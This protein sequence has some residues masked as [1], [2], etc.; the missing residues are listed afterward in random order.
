MYGGGTF[1]GREAAYQKQQ[2][3]TFIS[4]GVVYIGDIANN[5]KH[6]VHR[7]RKQTLVLV[8][9][10]SLEPLQTLAHELHVSIAGGKC[11]CVYEGPPVVNL[12]LHQ[13]IGRNVV[14]E[15]L[16]PYIYI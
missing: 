11:L 12:F 4:A 13:N 15:T 7:L 8:S 14:F 9:L 10:W 6:K 3:L 1:E 16:E 5:E 2:L